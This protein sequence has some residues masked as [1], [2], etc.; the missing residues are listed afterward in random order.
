[1]LEFLRVD[2][3]TV[4]VDEKLLFGDR[5]QNGG[6]LGGHG[7]A[8]TMPET[9]RKIKV[10]KKYWENSFFSNTQRRYISSFDNITA[11][12]IHTYK[13][14]KS[15]GGIRTRGLLFWRGPQK[16]SRLLTVNCHDHSV[17][18]LHKETMAT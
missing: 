13:D 18:T 9:M 16:I 1:L 17:F 5:L 3:G 4:D 15:P 7:R 6:D 10:L 12:Y 2:G 8:S 11:M 14:L